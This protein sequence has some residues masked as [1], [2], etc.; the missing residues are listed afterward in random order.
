MANLYRHPTDPPAA[1]YT[2][3]WCEGPSATLLDHAH[4]AWGEAAAIAWGPEPFRTRFRAVW[5]AEALVVRFDCLDDEPWWT[6]TERDAKLWNEEVVEIFLDPARTGLGYAEIEINP[7][8]VICDLRVDTPWPALS[9]D[10]GWD[11]AGMQSVVTRHRADGEAPSWTAI[12][13]LPFEG[14][15]TLSQEA[16][17]CMPPTAGDHW[18]FNVFR[19]KRPGGALDPERDAVYAAWSVPDGPSFHVPERFKELVFAESREP[20]VERRSPTTADRPAPADR[21][22]AIAWPPH[23]SDAINCAGEPRSPSTIN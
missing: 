2:V 19:I 18:R 8:N 13:V 9:S 14:V 6:F 20:T 1:D 7:A 10:P 5:T 16:A 23:S 17:R 11:W 12:A 4:A 3:C 22:S 15:R 21:R